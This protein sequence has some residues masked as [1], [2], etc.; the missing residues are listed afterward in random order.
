M[1][2]GISQGGLWGARVGGG[3]GRYVYGDR[4]QRVGASGSGPEDGAGRLR[5]RKTRREKL[6]ADRSPHNNV[7]HASRAGN[8]GKEGGRGRWDRGWLRYGARASGRGRTISGPGPEFESRRVRVARENTRFSARS[9][10]GWTRRRGGWRPG[11]RGGR[12]GPGRWFGPPRAVWARRCRA[13]WA[14]AGDGGRRRGWPVAPRMSCG[15][16]AGRV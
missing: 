5:E 9:K 4:A 14:G 8:G 6:P 3:V 12:W 7:M 11:R 1:P 13:I 10:P 2:R 15:E 16:G